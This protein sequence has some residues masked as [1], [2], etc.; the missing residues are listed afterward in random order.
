MSTLK[1]ANK[2][3]REGNFGKS[4]E[5]FEELRKANPNF[6]LY[7]KGYSLA[8]QNLKKH[9]AKNDDMNLIFSR[10]V[11]HPESKEPLATVRKMVI[12]TPV[13]NGAEF[14]AATLESILSQKGNFTIEY[15][16]MDGC[17]SDNTLDVLTDF[18][19]RI[20]NGNITLLCHGIKF[21]VQSA[22]DCGLYDAIAQGFEIDEALRDPNDILAY[23][24][25]DDVFVPDAFQIA[26]HVFENTKARW[27]CGQIHTIN[28]LGETIH[29]VKFPLTYSREDILAGHHL[30]GDLYFIQQEGNFWL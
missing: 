28:S 30:G 18:Q 11:I 16:V 20:E 4:L 22:P 5:V 17:S 1:L 6:S 19:N 13:Y 12:V 7:E 24:N 10:S 9:G 23:L 27:I 26:T 14:L 2:Y 3:L 15:S 25:A 8:R 21:T 29:S